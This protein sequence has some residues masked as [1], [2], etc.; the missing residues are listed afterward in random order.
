MV[1]EFGKK[2]VWINLSYDKFDGRISE[3]KIYRRIPT[4]AIDEDKQNTT[5]FRYYRWTILMFKRN[6]RWKQ[7]QRS[8]ASHQ[9]H[10]N[11]N[12]KKR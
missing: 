7:D 10:V 4:M 9:A 11:F 2:M 3:F 5:Q 6:V 12:H 1:I 8:I